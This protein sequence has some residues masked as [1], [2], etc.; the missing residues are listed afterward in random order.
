MTTK[1]ILENKYGIDKHYHEQMNIVEVSQLETELEFYQRS[2]AVTASIL[3]MHESEY[4]S[5]IQ[6][7]QTT[8]HQPLHILFIG[9]KTIYL[10]KY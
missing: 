1:Y 8:P 4:I 6:Q 10:M 9:I 2:H 7:G 5:Q 3:K